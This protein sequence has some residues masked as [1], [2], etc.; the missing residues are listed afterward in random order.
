MLVLMPMLADILAG[1]EMVLILALILVLFGT[2]QLPNIAQGLG[3]ALT[4]FRKGIDEAARNAGES[5]GGIYGK[6]AAEA[7]T[8]GNQTAELYDPA[9]FHKERSGRAPKRMRFRRWLRLWRA[10]WQSF[11]KR[12]KAKL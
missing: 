11:L 6:P 8:P 2:K 12:M 3:N 1:G 10:I 4:Q 7:L 9:V 5:L